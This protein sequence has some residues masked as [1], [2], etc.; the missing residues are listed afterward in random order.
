MVP[1]YKRKYR[2]KS[3]TSKE[4]KYI[5]IAIW[6]SVIIIVALAILMYRPFGH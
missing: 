2:F 3:D 1:D 5:N 4:K 6:I